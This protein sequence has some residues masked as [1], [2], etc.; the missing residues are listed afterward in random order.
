M[1][2]WLELHTG[3]LSR[4]LV[5]PWRSIDAEMRR[6]GRSTHGEVTHP[7]CAGSGRVR[8]LASG[9]IRGHGGH[10]LIKSAVGL[11]GWMLVRVVEKWIH[12]AQDLG[13]LQ[14]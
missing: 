4:T 5:W 1:L 3:C 12:H 10:V 11:Q 2:A 13:K 14:R 6:G 9:P 8:L 7:R